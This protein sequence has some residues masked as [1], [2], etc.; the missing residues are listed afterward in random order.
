MI[1]FL[2]LMMV[3]APSPAQAMTQ[4]S[5]IYCDEVLVELVRYQRDTGSLRDDDVARIMVNCNGW[6]E[7]YEEEV[8]SAK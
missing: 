2:A 5:G 6:E 7:K 8:E 1:S 4:W 3:S